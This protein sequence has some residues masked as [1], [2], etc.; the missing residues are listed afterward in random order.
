MTIDKWLSQGERE[1]NKEIKEE[2]NPSS[3]AESSKVPPEQKDQLMKKSIKK[4]INR[5]DETTP[6][7]CERSMEDDYFLKRILEFKNWL[8]NRTYLKGDRRKIVRWIIGLYSIIE[9]EERNSPVASKSPTN[10]R[11]ELMER[12]RNIPPRLLDEK[13]RVAINKKLN[14]RKRTSS[15]NYYLRKLKKNIHQKL[16]KL[17]YYRILQEITEL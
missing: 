12:F 9:D 15:D 17:K 11:Q 4:L 5:N 8:N 2:K 7:L 13:T 10:K 3:Q 16:K 1:Q 14:G 6:D